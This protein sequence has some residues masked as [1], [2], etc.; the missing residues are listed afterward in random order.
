MEQQQKQ[1]GLVEEL[2]FDSE[3]SIKI[4]SHSIEVQGKKLSIS[5]PIL[6]R[7]ITFAVAGNTFKVSSNDEN[8]KVKKMVNSYIAHVKN[9]IAGVKSPYIYKL[10]IC[11]GHFPMNVQLEKTK[12]VIKNF[13]GEKFPRTVQLKEGV[14]V[15]I[16]GDIITVQSADKELAGQ[17]SATIEQL[18]RRPGFDSRIFQDGIYIIDKGEAIR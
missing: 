4:H 10:K 12:F 3:V 1:K 18:T 7:N 2:E 11:S 6:H 9:M 5:R 17:T 8:K 15:S 14:I 16:E 13:L